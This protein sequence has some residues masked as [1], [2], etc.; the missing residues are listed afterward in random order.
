MG[1]VFSKPKA[2]DNSA[3]L[4]EMQRQ[5]EDAERQRAEEKKRE[6]NEKRK[7]EDLR[8]RLRRGR[9]SLLGTEGG[10]LGVE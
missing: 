2:P 3:Q 9:S 4:A 8:Q 1:G 5:R 10:E 7:Q 6:E